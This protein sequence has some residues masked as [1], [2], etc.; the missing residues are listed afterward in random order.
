[1][2][3]IRLPTEILDQIVLESNDFTVASTLRQ[4]ISE[5]VYDYTVKTVL[6]YGDVQGGKTKE[7]V[8]VLKSKYYGNNLKVLVIQNSLLVLKQYV[9]RLQSEGVEFQVITKDTKVINSKTVIVMGNSYRYKYFRLLCKSKYILIMDEADL[10]V[11]T[12]P[13]EGYKTYFVT[14][15]PYTLIAKVEFNEIINVERNSDYYGINEV[16]TMKYTSAKD[17]LL[18]FLNEKQGMMLITTY[19]AVSDM[20]EQAAMIS[21]SHKK[22]PVIVLSSLKMM[23]IGGRV[24]PLPKSAS[25]TSIIDNLCGYSHVVFIAHRLAS[26]GLSYTS[27]DYKRHLTHQVAKVQLDVT[28]FLQSLRL[29]GVYSFDEKLKLYI[30]ETESKRYETH[31]KY[32]NDFDVDVKN[33]ND[34]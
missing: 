21:E 24:L 6:I 13:L 19:T 15:T 27:S 30:E 23:Y 2:C 28:R 25:V 8:K 17:V 3:N 11:K 29:L 31:K 32:I 12:C 33:T 34:D 26:R 14:A 22:V 9:N 20:H 7:I 18:D 1:M 10:V 16:K 4:Y 5:Y